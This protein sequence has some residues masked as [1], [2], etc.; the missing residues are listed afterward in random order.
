MTSEQDRAAGGR[1]RRSVDLGDGRFACASVV[2]RLLP[3]TRRVR[4][5]LRWGDGRRSPERYLGEVDHGTRAA[6]LAEGWHRAAAKG[7][8]SEEPLPEGSKASSMAVRDSM[9]GNRGKDTKPEKRLRSLLHKHGL[10]YRVDAA[11]LIGL[12]RRADVVF[13]RAKVA[14][15]MDGCFWHACPE[16]YRPSTKNAERWKQK[17]EGNRLRD[18]ETVCLLEAAGWTVIRAWEHEDPARVARRVIVAVRGPQD[19]EVGG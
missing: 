8:L 9:R 5:Y 10:R 6:N 17:I 13:T 14:V 18:T 15:F 19:D 4:A 7:L 16:H 2:L 12:R 1:Y 3:N 11:P